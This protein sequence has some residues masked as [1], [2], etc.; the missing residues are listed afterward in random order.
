MAKKNNDR[1]LKAVTTIAKVAISTN[2]PYLTPLLLRE[3]EIADGL[4]R[5]VERRFLAGLDIAAIA[6]TAP[7]ELAKN[8]KLDDLN[9]A[10]KNALRLA[11]EASA[12]AIDVDEILDKQ[13][14]N[15]LL[16][17]M[18][19]DGQLDVPNASNASDLP[20]GAKGRPTFQY[21]YCV[22]SLPRTPK[23]DAESLPKR[24]F[25]NWE[26]VCGAIFTSTPDPQKANVIV[27]LAALTAMETFLR[28]RTSA[29]QMTINS[30]CASTNPKSGIPNI[31][32]R[33]R[34]AMRSGIC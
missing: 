26:A 2:A 24:C 20:P 9:K 7:A 10:I 33:P 14:R 15:W 32:S 31:N 21:Q 3:D 6:N 12:G 17:A 8:D 34:S 29:R 27:K 23:F 19:C 22:E 11:Q 25:S 16:T 28:T 30:S 13:T 4:K 5:L 18:G 1:P